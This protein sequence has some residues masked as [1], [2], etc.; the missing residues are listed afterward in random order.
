MFRAR[1]RVG[2]R[3]RVRVRRIGFRR[4]G[5]RRNG[6]EPFKLRIFPSIKIQYDY[7]SLE[8]AR[9]QSTVEWSKTAIFTQYCVTISSEPSAII[10]KL[11]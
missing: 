2:N 11:L 9:R 10:P 3:V 8:R 6:T 5:I 7:H 4:N 1:K